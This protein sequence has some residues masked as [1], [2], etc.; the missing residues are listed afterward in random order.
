MYVSR[1]ESRPAILPTDMFCCIA[2][3]VGGGRYLDKISGIYEWLASQPKR[4]DS[5]LVLVVDTYGSFNYHNDSS[6][7]DAELN[8]DLWF[9]LPP[10][11]LIRRYHAINAQAKK[12]MVDVLGDAV[13]Q[14]GLKQSIVFGA[15]KR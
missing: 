2:K 8:G 6:T 7:I 14:E 12:D 4:S 5:D 1:F 13:E 3:F 9:Q 11:T 15:G 10:E